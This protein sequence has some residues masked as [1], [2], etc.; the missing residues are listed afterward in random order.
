VIRQPGHAPLNAADVERVHHVSDAE[1][2]VDRTQDRFAHAMLVTRT[3]PFQ[4]PGSQG[5]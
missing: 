3:D 5:K 2:A 1:H 4:K